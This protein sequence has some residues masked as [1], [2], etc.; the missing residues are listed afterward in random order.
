MRA[1]FKIEITG[2]RVYGSTLEAVRTAEAE[3]TDASRFTVSGIY[4]PQHNVLA[5][6]TAPLA[7]PDYIGASME[8]TGQASCGCAITVV[9]GEHMACVSCEVDD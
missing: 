7:R 2:S 3:S 5:S 9:V 6:L 8:M 1:V 4:C